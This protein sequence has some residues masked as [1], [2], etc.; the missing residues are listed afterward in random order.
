MSEVRMEYLR[1]EQLVAEKQRRSLV[2]LPIGPLEWHGPHLPLGVDMLL[3]HEIAVRLAQNVGGVVHPALFCGTERER[4]PQMLRYLGFQGHEWIV[5]MDFPANSVHSLYYPEETLGL[6]LRESLSLLV[7]QGYRLIAIVNGHG[8]ENQIATVQR[9][10]AAFTAQG[11]ARVVVLLPFP[12]E[13]DEE[14]RVSTSAGHADL[15]ET[16]A[17]MALHPGVVH[18]DALPP[19]DQPLRNL[20]HAIVDSAT[21]SGNPTPDFTVRPERDPRRASAG[22]GEAQLEEILARLTEQMGEAMAVL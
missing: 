15:Y 13:T 22:T 6:M 19:P 12:V 3:A 16:S 21:F 14:G 4:P 9:L 11:R 20:D 8:A 2:F 18:L 7:E 5:G 10:A 1:P 17:M